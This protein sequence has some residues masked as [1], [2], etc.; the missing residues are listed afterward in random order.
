M[1]FERTRSERLQIC[2]RVGIDR[3][4]NSA[5]AETFPHSKALAVAKSFRRAEVDARKIDIFVADPAQLILP[6]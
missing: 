3:D 2:D 5:S 6:A 4:G 1:R